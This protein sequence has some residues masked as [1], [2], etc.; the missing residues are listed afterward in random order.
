MVIQFPRHPSYPHSPVTPRY[1]TQSQQPRHLESRLCAR[2]HPKKVRAD[3]SGL[4][5]TSTYSSNRGCFVNPSRPARR[6]ASRTCFWPQP[7][8]SAYV[9]AVGQNFCRV[10]VPNISASAFV[11][12]AQVEGPQNHQSGNWEKQS[13]G[14][15]GTVHFLAKQ[16]L[17][18]TAIPPPS[19][20][21]FPS[22]SLSFSTI[23]RWNRTP[24]VLVP[25]LQGTTGTMKV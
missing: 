2:S 13:D 1:Q 12:K 7:S 20:S 14:Y 19:L 4:G 21:P 17:E 25:C 16:W 22:L 15:Q 3:F 9:R 5:V 6:T 11:P 18:H 10:P 8:A 23:R 24:H